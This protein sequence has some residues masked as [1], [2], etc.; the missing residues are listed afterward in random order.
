MDYLPW[1]TSGRLFW[2][3]PITW[4]EHLTSQIL[5]VAAWLLVTYVCPLCQVDELVLVFYGL[6]SIRSWCNFKE[7]VWNSRIKLRCIASG[8]WKSAGIHSRNLILGIKCLR[9]KVNHVKRNVSVQVVSKSDF[10][11]SGPRCFPGRT[12]FLIL[13]KGTKRQGGFKIFLCGLWD[14]LSVFGSS[15]SCWK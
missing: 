11:S 9:Y 7:R 15:V 1:L 8:E 4:G 13:I 6:S 5:L 10:K 14:G 12:W 2:L 3:N